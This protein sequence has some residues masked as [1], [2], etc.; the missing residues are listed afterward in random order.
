[1]ALITKPKTWADAENV[2]YTDMNSNLDTL[3][4]E[5]NGN[6]DNDNIAANADI[7]IEK[8][9][10][11]AMN[12]T[13][14]QTVTGQK[15]FTSA[16]F[17]DVTGWIEANET[18]TYASADDPTFTLTIS[19]D[20][21]SKYSAGMRVKLTQTTDKFFIITKVAYSSPNTT[22]TL[23]GG[24][25]YDLANA[26]I[27]TPYYSPDKAPQGFP[28][29]PAKWTVSYTD[30]SSRTQ[31]SPTQS[32]WYNL[33]TAKVDIPIGVW[34]V[35]YFVAAAVSNSTPVGQLGI[36]TTLSTANN[37]ESDAQFTD[38]G[39]YQLDSALIRNFQL[40]AHRRKTLTLTSKT[41]YYLNTVT[42]Y[43]SQTTLYNEGNGTPTM[44]RAICALL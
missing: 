39:V 30:T 28:L 37:S 29:D 34:D 4:T 19:G 18:W 27:T 17:R 36:R 33:N 7:E 2:N 11:V 32:T 14:D 31:S 23:Y 26:T 6:L 41:S 44:I 16:I 1:M 10:G 24:T 12:L 35:S 8:I 15:T 40:N 22:L 38:Y 25:D 5:I 42:D 9:E 3:Y 21:T 43:A 13:D 20:K